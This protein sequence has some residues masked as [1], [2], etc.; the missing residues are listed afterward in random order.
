M[1]GL[2]L[3]A[4]KNGILLKMIKQYELRRFLELFGI[5]LWYV[6]VYATA[7]ICELC[8]YLVEA[9]ELGYFDFGEL[10]GKC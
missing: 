6:Y 1:I 7:L 3:F 9:V 2:G 8:I 4:L 5:G 10:I